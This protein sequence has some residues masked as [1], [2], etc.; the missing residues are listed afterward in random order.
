MYMH[1]RLCYCAC[2][3]T[4]CPFVHVCLLMWEHVCERMGAFICVHVCGHMQ[5]LSMLCSFRDL[6]S[7][8]REAPDWR[9]DVRC[10]RAG[11]RDPNNSQYFRYSNRYIVGISVSAAV[12]RTYSSPWKLLGPPS[13]DPGAC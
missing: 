11:A 13:E 3:E 2:K 1:V 6:Q 5:G 12:P 9:H 4:S 10:E 8:G 7:H